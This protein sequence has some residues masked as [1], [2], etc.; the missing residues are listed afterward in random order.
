ML[1]MYIMVEFEGIFSLYWRF[2]YTR[3]F[4]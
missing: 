1:F 2:W 3:S 4:L